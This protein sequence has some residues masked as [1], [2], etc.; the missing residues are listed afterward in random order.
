MLRD[1]FR[2]ACDLLRAGQINKKQVLTFDSASRW[3]IIKIMRVFV[4]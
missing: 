1:S 3:R 4:I 2:S